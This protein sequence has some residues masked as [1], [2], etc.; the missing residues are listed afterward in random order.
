MATEG[1]AASISIT[2]FKI[3]CNLRGASSDKKAAVKIPKGT[4]ISIDPSETNVN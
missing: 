3:I 1:I 4:A 2:G